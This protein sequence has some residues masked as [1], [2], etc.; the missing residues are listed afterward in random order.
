MSPGKRVGNACQGIPKTCALMERF[1]EATGC[2]RGQVPDQNQNQN[3]FS[4]PSNQSSCL[5]SYSFAANNLRVKR[6]FFTFSSLPV[7]AGLDKVLGDAA[8]DSRLAS[9]W[10]HQLQAADAPGPRHPGAGLQDPL[11]RPDQVSLCC[12]SHRAK[13]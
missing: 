9:Y 10:T 4:V 8:W 12:W 2:K 7:A 1:P 13:V 11:H 6:V 5:V 3:L